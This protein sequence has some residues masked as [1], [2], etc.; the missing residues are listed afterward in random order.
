MIPSTTPR[1]TRQF[2]Y[3][4]DSG[5][6]STFIRIANLV[7]II[8]PFLGVITA[9][10]LLW[11]TDFSWVELGLLVSMYLLTV[12][13]ITIGFHRLFTHRSFET[14][15]T[16][17]CIL[18]ILGSMAAQGP[19]LKWVAIHRFHHR[20]SDVHGDPHSPRIHGKGFTGF[21]RGLWY[22]HMGWF[23]APD[24]KDLYNYVK[25]LS[26]SKLL[27]KL[28]TL[29]P[30]WVLLGLAIPTALGG[31]VTGTWLGALLG[32]IWGGLVRMFLVHHVTWGINSI[33]HIWGRR[34]FKTDDDSRNNLLFGILAL[35]E[36]WHNNHH[37]F[38]TSA[39]HGLRWWQI[40]ISYWIIYFLSIFGLVKKVRLARN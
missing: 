39:R 28:S 35:G 7:T 31:V 27:C 36:G 25:D 5:P 37:A 38:P 40:D 13:G 12:L 15:R 9:V 23:F 14:N 24:P 30:L 3:G 22:S 16:I 34:P 19:L 17:Q 20:Y 1:T 26:R 2:A 33:C 21:I 4:E 29:F 11:Y 6:I 32:L 10:I 8:I 18:A